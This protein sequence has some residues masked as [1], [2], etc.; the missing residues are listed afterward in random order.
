MAE[1]A[2]YL[3]I[4]AGVW[5]TNVMIALLLYKYELRG[6]KNRLWASCI[7]LPALVCVLVVTVCFLTGLIITVAITLAA[8]IVCIPIFLIGICFGALTWPVIAL[9]PKGQTGSAQD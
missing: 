6:Q 5:V 8:V 9:L 1:W 3:L 2:T 4:A 7:A